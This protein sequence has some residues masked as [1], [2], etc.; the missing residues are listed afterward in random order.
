[1]SDAA[2]YETAVRSMVYHGNAWLAHNKGKIKIQ[3]NFSRNVAVAMGVDEAITHGL[4][5]L[6]DPAKDFVSR[7]ICQTPDATVIMLKIA[8][9]LLEREIGLR[10]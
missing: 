10:R 4:L 3:F 1:M 5:S 7:M 9:E 8:L 6:D 2:H